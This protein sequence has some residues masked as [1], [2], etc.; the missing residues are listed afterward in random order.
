MLKYLQESAEGL[1]LCTQESHSG[2]QEIDTHT[3]KNAI[4]ATT[5]GSKHSKIKN[6]NKNMTEK[7]KNTGEII[8][9]FWN[10]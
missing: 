1:N 3:Q 4:K 6:K 8:S 5:K 10:L 2:C 7:N 9:S